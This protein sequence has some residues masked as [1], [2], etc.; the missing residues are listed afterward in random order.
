[1]I[2]V[3]GNNSLEEVVSKAVE[4]LNEDAKIQAKDYLKATATLTD[5][6][7]QIATLEIERDKKQEEFDRR[8]REVEHKVGLERKRQEFEITQS[9]REA[10][11]QVKEENLTTD[12][13]RFKSEMDFQRTHLEA[14]VK[15]LRELVT[16]MLKRLPSAEIFTTIGSKEQ[17]HVS[18]R[19]DK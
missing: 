7:K 1:M 4:R 9:K 6:R 3:W 8:E 2:F 14:E 17:G 16:E 18:S 12:K 11:V 15:S 13:A 10:T 5:L 19:H